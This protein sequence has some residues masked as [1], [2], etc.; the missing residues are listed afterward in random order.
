MTGINPHTLFTSIRVSEFIGILRIGNQALVFG[1]LLHLLRRF[2]LQIFGLYR[3]RRLRL[4]VVVNKATDEIV[5]PVN[6]FAARRNANASR[7]T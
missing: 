2:A 3:R 1:S 4:I 6:N 7:D 5:D